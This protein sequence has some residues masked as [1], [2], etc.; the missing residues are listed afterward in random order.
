MVQPLVE[1]AITHGLEGKESNGILRISS[2]IRD[3]ELVIRVYD[4]GCG[5]DPEAIKRIMSGEFDISKKKSSNIGIFNVRK[6]M[7]LYYGE[8]YGLEIISKIGEFTEIILRFPIIN[9]GSEI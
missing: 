1:N 9:E 5:I 7:E 3:E 6:R 2:Q 4:N 8:K